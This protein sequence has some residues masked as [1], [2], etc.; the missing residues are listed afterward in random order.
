MVES[1]LPKQVTSVSSGHLPC[2]G[3]RGGMVFSNSLVEEKPFPKVLIT[4][5][6]SDQLAYISAAVSGIAGCIGYFY[7]AVLVPVVI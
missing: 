1:S 2:H 6:G 3:M 7:V 4:S 5:R